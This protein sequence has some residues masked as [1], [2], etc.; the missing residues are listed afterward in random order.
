MSKKIISLIL[1]FLLSINSCYLIYASNFTSEEK[2]E[3]DQIYGVDNWFIDETGLVMPKDVTKTPL[4]EDNTKFESFLG[5]ML[6]GQVL[7][8]P[9]LWASSS[10]KELIKKHIESKD[11]KVTKDNG[12]EISEKAAEELYKSFYDVTTPLCGY[13]LLEPEITD[14]SILKTQYKNSSSY[15]QEENYKDFCTYIDSHDSFFVKDELN[16]T[17]PKKRFYPI[18]A[19][20]FYYLNGS[21]LYLYNSDGSLD[22]GKSALVTGYRITS[23]S[24][25]FYGLEYSNVSYVGISLSGAA[26]FYGSPFK[27]F[28]T[29]AD[30]LS[31]LNQLNGTEIP[32]IYVNSNFFNYSPQ[33]YAF[34]LRKYLDTDWGGLNISTGDKI[35]NNIKNAVTEKGDSL[36]QEEMQQ[37][38][39]NAVKEL[40]DTI[41]NNSGGGGG[42]SGGGT[43]DLSTIENWLSKIHSSV[44]NF[45]ISTESNFKDLIKAVKDIGNLGSD[46][47]FL[48]KLLGLIGDALSTAAGNILSDLIN[49]F[50]GE[51]GNL[52]DGITDSASALATQAQSK[53]PTCI[54]WDVVMIL[55]Y[56]NAEPQAPKIEFPFKVESVGIDETISLDFSKME[57]LAKLSRSMLTVTFLLFLVIQTRKLYG[58]LNDG[59]D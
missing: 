30:V 19:N 50:I 3:Y 13:Y 9:L 2:S 4:Y 42:D 12:I 37:I 40:Q 10:I 39:D 6:F 47:S 1:I 21:N 32:D 57:P 23:T 58:A 8:E 5:N 46:E 16:D 55:G 34:D 38:I 14:K 48:D 7:H 11:I 22:F 28:Y 41:N 52:L 27:I 49:L 26:G 31:F 18:S 33:S 53:F 29:K 45:K 44:E 15:N 51:D 54:P 17:F 25:Y 36:T 20:K 56:F 35:T 24:I 43:T 59:G